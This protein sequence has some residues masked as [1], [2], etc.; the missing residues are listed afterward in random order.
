MPG[1]DRG[2]VRLRHI[3]RLGDLALGPVPITTPVGVRPHLDMLR[4]V[5]RDMATTD[6]LS[7]L[8]GSIAQGLVEH[9]GATV[10]RVFLYV[11]EDECPICQAQ[12]PP[13]VFDS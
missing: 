7:A 8:L 10:A 5:T 6:D 4:R 9:A 13:K 1:V 12:H 3:T 2:L 11:A